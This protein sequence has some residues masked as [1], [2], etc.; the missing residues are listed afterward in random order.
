M[1][2]SVYIWDHVATL[3]SVRMSG[4]PIDSSRVIAGDGSLCVDMLLVDL[5]AAIREAIGSLGRVERALAALHTRLHP[6]DESV[7]VSSI[8][9]NQQV[10]CEE[11]LGRED[12]R[13]GSGLDD[14]L[15]NGLDNGLDQWM[16]RLIQDNV[17]NT[18]VAHWTQKKRD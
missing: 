7:A 1:G 16:A 8:G 4:S 5:G 10:V 6:V 18:T 12:D 17:Q 15:D 2:V 3:G 11:P 13:L 14:G 9:I